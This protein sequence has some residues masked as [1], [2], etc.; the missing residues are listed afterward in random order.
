MTVPRIRDIRWRYC[1]RSDENPAGRL[2]ASLLRL[3]ICRVE[4]WTGSAVDFVER[5]F[6][7][8]CQANGATHARKIWEGNLLIMDHLFQLTE[9]ERNE[10]RADIDGPFQTLYMVADFTSAASIPIGASLTHLEKEHTLLPAAFYVAFIHHLWKWMRV[11]DYT[12]AHDHA[13]MGMVDMDEDQLQD[14]VY[15]KVDTDIPACLKGRLKMNPARALEL[16][17]ELYPKL[18]GSATRQLVG[19]LLEMHKHSLGRS[20]AWPYRLERR[21]PGLGDYLDDSDGVGPGCLISWYEDDAI[22]ACF[23]EEMGYMGLN[24]PLTPSILLP[25]KLDQSRQ[26]LDAQVSRVFGYAGAMLR[27]LAAAAKTVELIRELYDENLRQHRIQSGLQ[28]QPRA[29]GV[30]EE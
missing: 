7:R 19:H 24:G 16:L 11:Y 9:R 3:G 5:G 2:G 10:V 26:A 28:T 14:S 29:S 30:R 25:I 6:T 20:H 23:D 18:R 22:G 8:F 1:A 12:S 27:S 21:I 15:A 17:K 4:D 13:E